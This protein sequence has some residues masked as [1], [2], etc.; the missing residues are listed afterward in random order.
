MKRIILTESQYKRLVRQTL[1][2]QKTKGGKI[3]LPPHKSI[4]NVRDN[5]AEMYLLLQWVSRY[6][7][8]KYNENLHIKDISDSDLTIDLSKY[9]KKVINYIEYQIRSF[10]K[11]YGKILT[12]N[13]E[14]GEM[15][16]KDKSE[17]WKNYH[18]NGQLSSEGKYINGKLL[19]EWKFYYENGQ[20]K[21]EGKYV[22]GKYEGEWKS[23]HDNGQLKTQGKYVNGKKEGDWRRYSDNGQLKTKGK[24][25]NGKMEGKWISFNDNGQLRQEGKFVNGKMEGEWKFFHDNGQLDEI[26]NYNNGERVDKPEGEVEDI[27]TFH[28]NGQLK[29]QG[30]LKDGKY[31]GEWK[32]F[33]EDGQLEEEGNYVNG[34]EEGEWKRYYDN[35][36]LSSEGKYVNGNSEGEWKFYHKNGQLI[37]Q[38]KYVNGKKEGETKSYHDNGQLSS[39]RKYV[40]DKREGETKRYYDNGQLKREEKYVNGEMEGEWKFFHDNGQLKEEGKYVNG[41]RKGEWKFYH[42]NGQLDEIVNYNNGEEVDNPEEVID[43]SEDDSFEIPIPNDDIKVV[44]KQKFLKS[45]T[46]EKVDVDYV[47]DFFKRKGLK[48]YQSCGVLGNIYHESTFNT[49]IVGDGGTSMGLCQWHKGR[50]KKLSKYSK[51]KGKPITD[52]DLQL[53]FL[54]NEIT[55]THSYVLKGIRDSTTIKEASF[56][57]ASKFEVCS[58]CGEEDSPTNKKRL[59]KG[60]EYLKRYGN[61]GDE[62]VPDDVP[63]IPF[64]N[65]TEGN[66]FRKWVNDN[67]KEYAEKIDLDPTG[68]WEEGQKYFEGYML[69]AWNE[70][71]KDYMDGDYYKELEEISSNDGGCELS[72]CQFRVKGGG[73]K[74]FDDLIA[75]SKNRKGGGLNFDKIP[76]GKNNFRSAAPSAE[77]MLYI[78]QNNP[79]IENIISFDHGKGGVLMK[80]KE[81]KKFIECYN[82][83]NGTNIKWTKIDAH[84]N[85]QKGKGYVGTLDEVLPLDDNTLIHCTHGA[86]RTGYVVAKHL[87]DLGKIGTNEDLWKYTVEYNSW[88]GKNGYICKGNKGYIKYLEGFYPHEEWCGVGNRM[89]DCPSCKKDT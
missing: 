21:Q 82:E 19:G 15:Y 53:G 43:V 32:Q 56:V 79:N 87:K 7:G 36:Q 51:M 88:E 26:V 25:V 5:N 2:E 68:H 84:N 49:G 16:F 77:Q 67:H 30:K 3:I 42:D 40:N 39:E 55:G 33:W 17:E 83:S 20:L 86:D 44:G 74:P 28:D 13:K 66:A 41:E 63:D 69:K 38:R 64:R 52:K 48:D 47:F 80:N 59:K 70:Y 73:C 9:K 10:M 14:S 22:N 18:D 12:Y 46:N 58:E 24:Y 57:W 34:N 60:E 81:E 35:G 78:L 29:T 76:D 72:N 45:P 89:E 75:D 11:V 23:Y 37:T 50:L 65:K 8:S 31:E 61:V 1:N 62:I 27:E 4:Y 71:G 6:L 54:W 85:F